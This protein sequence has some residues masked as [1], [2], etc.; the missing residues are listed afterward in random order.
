MKYCAYCGK[1]MEDMD[2]FCDHCGQPAAAAQ[3]PQYQQSPY[4]YAPTVPYNAPILTVGIACVISAVVVWL[5]GM[6]LSTIMTVWLGLSHVI[7]NLIATVVN[8]AI[9]LGICFGGVA[10]YNSQCKTHYHY[11]LVIS[12]AW[13]LLP[14]GLRYVISFLLGLLTGLIYGIFGYSVGLI[15]V[16]NFVTVM[17]NAGI[18]AV[19]TCVILKA[20]LNS[21]RR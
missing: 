1:P 4:G 19:L 21:K 12:P 18:T 3:L 5:V 20:Y 14:F 11:E 9:Y 15:T 13:A 6:A 10:I 8:T 17:M 16:L 2:K 7:Y